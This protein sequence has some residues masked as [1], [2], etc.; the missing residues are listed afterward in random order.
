MPEVSGLK[1]VSYEY[2][3]GI[4]STALLIFASLFIYA[5]TLLGALICLAEFASFVGE[6]S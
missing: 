6:C 2:G 3:L 1:L 4:V 5:P